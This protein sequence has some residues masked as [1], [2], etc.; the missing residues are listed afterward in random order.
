MY[1]TGK[2]REPLLILTQPESFGNVACIN[3]DSSGVSGGVLI[4]SVERR[5]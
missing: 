4:V 5:H 2:M 3:C 1:E